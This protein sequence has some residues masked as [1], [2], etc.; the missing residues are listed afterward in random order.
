M[1]VSL[2]KFEIVVQGEFHPNVRI[3]CTAGLGA[4]DEGVEV[5]TGIDDRDVWDVFQVLEHRG[6]DA[7]GADVVRT[8]DLVPA[9]PE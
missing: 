4:A 2:V 3:L 1:V 5:V 9:V 8:L 6:Q 7:M